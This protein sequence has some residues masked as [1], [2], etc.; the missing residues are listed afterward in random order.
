[1]QHFKSDRF[2]D[3]DTISRVAECTIKGTDL[4]SQ[5]YDRLMTHINAIPDTEKLLFIYRPKNSFE[6]SRLV[7][8]NNAEDIIGLTN[9][10]IFKTDRSVTWSANLD[11][12]LSV[13][14]IRNNFFHWDML[15]CRM[16]DGKYESFGIYHKST[17]GFFT[18]QI[19]EMISNRSETKLV[20][21]LKHE[22]AETLKNLINA[23]ND[24]KN[25]LLGLINDSD[26]SIDKLK[27]IIQDNQ[28]KLSSEILYKEQVQNH[29]EE[30]EAEIR[31]LNTEISKLSH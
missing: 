8:G 1:M 11:N 25:S 9:I 5:D 4:N 16:I 15:E 23:C 26:S 12:I 20:D 17:C 21:K 3:S 18:H 7:L 29:L 22:R 14:H 27:Q 31:E 6:K 13:Y 30:C 10:R 2:L 28:E 19:T 24:K